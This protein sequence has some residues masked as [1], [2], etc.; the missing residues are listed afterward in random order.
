LT[1]VGE[2]A[3]QLGGAIAALLEVEQLRRVV[4]ELGDDIAGEARDG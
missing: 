3:Q 2:I 4:D 1:V